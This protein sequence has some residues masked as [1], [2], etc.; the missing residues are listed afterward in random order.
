RRADS[1]T[2]AMDGPDA[3]ADE[4]PGD[5]GRFS[6]DFKVGVTL[7]MVLLAAG[8]VVLALTRPGKE[9]K[10]V[11]STTVVTK[12]VP[13]PRLERPIAALGKRL[14][15]AAGSSA[16]LGKKVQAL[17]SRARATSARIDHLPTGTT[18]AAKL[19]TRLA[20][21]EA[22]LT[23]RL[24]T[25]NTCLF[26]LQKQLDDIQAYYGTGSRLRKRVSGAC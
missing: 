18:A 13:D 6:L 17:E 22:Q 9:T 20:A 11:T 24:A 4:P 14:A 26:Q 19:R 3:T 10:T 15:A 16:A 1:S 5:R 2:R 12:K 7:V 25:V 23:A 21:L 8:L